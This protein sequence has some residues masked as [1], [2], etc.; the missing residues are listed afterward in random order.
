MHF[1]TQKKQKKEDFLFG[2]IIKKTYICT[3][4]GSI[5]IYSYQWRKT[6]CRCLQYIKI[7]RCI[8]TV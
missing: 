2:Q 7:I 5:K 3:S 6:L 1:P 4:I 8:K